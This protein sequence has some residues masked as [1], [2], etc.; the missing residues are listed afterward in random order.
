[1]EDFQELKKLVSIYEDQCEKTINEAQ[2]KEPRCS[3][4]K[5]DENNNTIHA[6]IEIDSDKKDPAW[7]Q[8]C[9]M[10]EK[11]GYFPKGP[12]F[13][14]SPDGIIRIQDVPELLNK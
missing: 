8:I 4:T 3:S 1:M 5:I 12:I 9:T 14:V 11:D 7:Q 10:G 2:S 13:S 6:K